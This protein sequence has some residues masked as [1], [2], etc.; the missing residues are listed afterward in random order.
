M[1]KRWFPRNSHSPGA[2]ALFAATPA[3]N[4][5]IVIAWRRV[6]GLS[7]PTV[8][9][10]IRRYSRYSSDQRSSETSFQSA[11]GFG[12][13]SVVTAGWW[14]AVLP[15]STVYQESLGAS[16]ERQRTSATDFVQYR[17]IFDF[18]SSSDK[19]RLPLTRGQSTR[20]I[21][22]ME[23]SRSRWGNDRLT[24]VP[25]QPLPDCRTKYM[26]RLSP[27][28]SGCRFVSKA[29]QSHFKFRGSASLVACSS[30]R[31]LCW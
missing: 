12:S 24:K 13:T 9:A 7:L 15:D 29:F 18:S 23:D 19:K 31:K 11:R 2:T 8:C 16:V 21:V 6:A 1:W 3:D 26:L 14:L 25:I 20:D 22:L 4:R 5:L 10:T 17:Q 27:F 30:D 28:A